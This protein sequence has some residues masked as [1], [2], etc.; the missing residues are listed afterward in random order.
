MELKIKNKTQKR[1]KKFFSI[2]KNKNKD[3]NKMKIGSIEIL[4]NAMKLSMSHLIENANFLEKGNN[5][6]EQ[7]WK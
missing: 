6:D 5:Q 1:K 3:K 2:N 7:I 4:Y